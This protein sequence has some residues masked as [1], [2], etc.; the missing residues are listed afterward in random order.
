[1]RIVKIPG[2]AMLSRV[3]KTAVCDWP[4]CGDD[5][6]ALVGRLAERGLHVVVVLAEVG[7]GVLQRDA[8]LLLRLLERMPLDAGTGRATKLPLAARPGPFAG[9]RS[10]ASASSLSPVTFGRSFRATNR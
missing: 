1:M 8:R 3:S 5:G 6:P 2:P 9:K 10:S 4:V 7:L